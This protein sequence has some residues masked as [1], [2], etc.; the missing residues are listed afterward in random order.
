VNNHQ[1]QPQSELQTH[2]SKAEFDVVALAA[3][4]GGLNALLEVLSALPVDFPA[5]IVI[6]QHSSPKHPSL[7]AQILNRNTSLAVK[8]AEKGDI[9]TPGKVY[10]APP[11]RLLLVNPDGTLDLKDL[12]V[13][14]LVFTSADVLFK[15]VAE[16]YQKKAIA[17]VLS[18]TGSDGAKG[19]KEI[20]KMGGIVIAQNE[21]TS[22]FFGMPKS[23]ISTQTV[24]LILP[25]DRIASTLI[26]LVCSGNS[27]K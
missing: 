5:A 17:V 2:F 16:S 15:S 13:N 22:Q 26:S 7:V 27:Q 3:S 19:V 23:A 14:V 11:D 24:D 8:E 20:K 1:N 4:A 12:N 18:G 25:I 6:V 10:V 21:E 9:L